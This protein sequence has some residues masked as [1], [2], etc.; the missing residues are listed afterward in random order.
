MGLPLEFPHGFEEYCIWSAAQRSGNAAGYSENE[1]FLTRQSSVQQ[2]DYN[3]PCHAQNGFRQKYLPLLSTASCLSAS[4]RKWL[5]RA[6]RSSI[7]V[8]ILT[9]RKSV[10]NFA[11]MGP[12]HHVDA[13]I[14][15]ESEWSA[16]I[17]AWSPEERRQQEKKLV[18]KIDARLL[19]I[20]FIMYILNYVDR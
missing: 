6:D 2:N 16:K 11:I 7:V 9:A 20:L 10:V 18:R 8:S 5:R 12:D 3:S 17:A 1:G 4:Q 13:P 14:G 19:P 15:E